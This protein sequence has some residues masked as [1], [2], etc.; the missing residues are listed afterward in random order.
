MTI[1]LPAPADSNNLARL[2]AQIEASTNFTDVSVTHYQDDNEIEVAAS[3]DGD[4]IKET[5]LELIVPLVEAHD[6]APTEEELRPERVRTK[7]D[8]AIDRLETAHAAWGQPSNNYTVGKDTALKL[9]VL[10]VAKTARF[11][12]RKFDVP[13]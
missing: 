3:L 12:L 4:P 9:M 6:P 11:V 2:A 8:D 13:E 10:V 7:L 1:R 5:H